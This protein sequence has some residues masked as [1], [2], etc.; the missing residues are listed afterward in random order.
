[1]RFHKTSIA[2][3]ALALCGAMPLAANAQ[4]TTPT[5]TPTPTVTATTITTTS[6]ASTRPTPPN[7]LFWS[8]FEGGLALATPKNC[9]SNGCFQTLSGKDSVTGFSWP[10]TT[11]ANSSN[12]FQ[13]LVNGPTPDPSTVGNWMSNRLQTVPGHKGGST[14]ALYSEIFQSGCCGTNPQGGAATQDTFHVYP[15]EEPGDIYFSKWIKLQPDLASNLAQGDPWRMVFEWKTA[16]DFRVLLEIVAWGGQTPFW[17]VSW[18]NDANGGLPYQQFYRSENHSVPVPMGDW[19]KLEVFWH[20]SSGTDGRAWFAINGKVIDDHFGQT[21]GV[22]KA[23]I[24]R[25]MINQVY[26]GAPYPIYQWIDDVQIW[27][28]FPTVQSTDPWYDPPYAPH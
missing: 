13:L 20:R 2:V 10:I 27:Q 7:L 16:G 25:I 1:M 21:I 22:N 9:Y 18:D 3:A 6:R 8:G 14:Q 5:V 17:Y 26:S 15:R 23:P 12:Q 11:V 24:N 4:T 19:F 28:G